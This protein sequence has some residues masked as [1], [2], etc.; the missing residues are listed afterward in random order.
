MPSPSA[1]LHTA[2]CGRV[3]R[4]RSQEPAATSMQTWIMPT[5]FQRISYCTG[6]RSNGTK[7]DAP[8]VNGPAVE[9]NEGF[10]HAY[11]GR[12]PLILSTFTVVFRLSTGFSSPPLRFVSYTPPKP[13][14]AFK[15]ASKYK[16]FQKIVV[17]CSITAGTPHMTTT[18]YCPKT[19][20]LT[21]PRFRVC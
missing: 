11:D 19:S 17:F 1:S 7:N 4:C 12:K 9:K 20:R 15:E 8:L 3:Y 6:S 13:G 2:H 21:C 14:E 5:S 10:V 16:Q 18:P